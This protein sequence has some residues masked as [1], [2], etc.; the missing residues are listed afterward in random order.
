M[1]YKRKKGVTQRGHPFFL[2]D[3]NKLVGNSL[4][5]Q[6]H[7]LSGEGVGE[8]D[9]HADNKDVDGEGLDHS[10]TDH[11]GGQDFAAGAGITGHAFNGALDRQTLTDTGTEGTDPHSQT[12]CEHTITEKIHGT[13]P[14]NCGGLVFLY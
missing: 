6:L 3:T 12:C 2:Y 8:E 10:Q 9:D 1:A 7:H 11:H 14:S 4:T 13:S 5:G